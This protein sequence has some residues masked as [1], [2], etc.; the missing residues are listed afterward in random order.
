[1]EKP[2]KTSELNSHPAPPGSHQSSISLMGQGD[3]IFVLV[4][5]YFLPITYLETKILLYFIRIQ[6][7]NNNM[8]CQGQQKK[9]IVQA[10]KDY[11]KITRS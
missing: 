9:N 3:T 8:E 11:L 6:S 7:L 10:N 2:G 4:V 1:M 5:Q